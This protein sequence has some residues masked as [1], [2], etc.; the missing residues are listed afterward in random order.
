[1]KPTNPLYIAL[2]L[3]AVFLVVVVKLYQANTAHGEAV[4]ALYETQTMAKRTAALKGT[5]GES[6]KN[7]TALKRLLGGSLLRDAGVEME[8][9]SDRMVISAKSIDRKALEY[10]MNKLLNGTYRIKNLKVKRLDE[11]QASFYAEVAL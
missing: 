9:R 1:V 11:R 8:K 3:I 4:V 7:A 10:L 5:W 6:T 2:L